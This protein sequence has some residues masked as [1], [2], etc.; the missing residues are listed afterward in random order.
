VP[1]D[2][3]AP[4]ASR[5]PAAQAAPADGRHLD[6][7]DAAR[8]H[9]FDATALLCLLFGEEGADEVERLLPG[10]LVSTV[11]YHEV[12][13]KLADLGVSMTE[14]RAMFDE[15]VV[16]IVA[17]DR[18]QADVGS[19][20]RGRSKGTGLSLGERSCL[21]LAKTR[22]AIAVTTDAAWTGLDYGITITVIRQASK[23]T[24]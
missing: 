16:E 15:L 11:T 2:G 8:R 22:S 21:A 18:Q 7:A 17:V 12:L 13:A 3:A 9:V 14:A 6:D 19:T 24:A 10:A 23:P 20:L 4:A 1:I 5:A